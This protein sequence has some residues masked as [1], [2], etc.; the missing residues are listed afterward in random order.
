MA[1]AEWL[2][3]HL[4]SRQQHMAWHELCKADDLL[5]V[6]EMKANRPEQYPDGVTWTAATHRFAGAYASPSV[7]RYLLGQRGTAEEYIRVH[8]D[9]SNARMLLLVHGHAWQIPAGL[10]PQVEAAEDRR[11]AW[12]WACRQ[13]QR[14]G[15]M[16][17]CLSTL[18]S[19]LI[20]RIAWEADIDF[21]WTLFKSG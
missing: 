6:V 4:G 16:G 17:N 11:L 10:A 13:H 14:Q 7:L 19:E 15:E 21:S 5:L 12:Y 1:V 8:P 18:P 20:K 2:L 3:G 9:C